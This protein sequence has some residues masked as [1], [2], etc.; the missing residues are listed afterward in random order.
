MRFTFAAIVLTLAGVA[1]FVAH[2]PAQGNKDQ[3]REKKI[4]E[5]EK[6]IRELQ[7]KITRKTKELASLR[8][9][10]PLSDVEL[11]AA[12]KKAA[13]GRSKPNVVE[14]SVGVKA[15]INTTSGSGWAA[16]AFERVQ[17]DQ[18][19]PAQVE[20]NEMRDIVLWQRPPDGEKDIRVVG[21]AWHRYGY[22]FFFTGKL[23][24]SRL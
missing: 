24:K 16:L 2:C 19:L 3:D 12:V 23:V 17:L 22:V 13:E 14:G 18:P 9:E 20:L 5:L 4:A 21:I 7:E 15:V 11:L 8:R 6:E 10:K 1:V